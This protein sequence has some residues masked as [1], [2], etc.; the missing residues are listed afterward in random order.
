MADIPILSSI[1]GSKP[2]IAGYTPTT[3]SDEQLKA[4]NADL[5]AWPKIQEIGNLFQTYLLQGYSKAIPGFMDILK[6][7]GATTQQMLSTAG[8]ELQ[9]QVPQD[10]QDQLQRS[11][12]YQS[13]I[14]SGAT[15]AS[16][17]KANA[18]RNLGLTSLNMIQSGAQLAGEAG[19]AAQRWANLSGAGQASNVMSGMLI[20][21]Q[22]QAALTMQNNLYKQATQQLQYNVN[23]APNPIAKGLSDIVEN[24]T[25]A[26]LGGKV[27]TIGAGNAQATSAAT[28][29]TSQ[30]GAG[31]AGNY[32]FSNTPGIAPTSFNDTMPLPTA[33]N[34]A[35]YGG[36]YYGGYGGV[37]PGYNGLPANPFTD[38]PT[39]FWDTA[40][41]NTN[42]PTGG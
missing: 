16:M 40:A 37:A 41:L 34:T 42:F 14:S 31:G 39:N 12:A 20:T 23:A 35:G 4:L 19:N 8:Q 38:M 29:L 10:V 22:Q 24:L 30:G 36:G 11:S 9:G 15:G 26:Y 32:A 1:F 21:P 13:F 6:A 17:D 2:Q 27:G 18:L 3:F 25:A 5:A 7:G 28:P 33:N